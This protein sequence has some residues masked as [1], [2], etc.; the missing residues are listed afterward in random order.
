MEAGP[1]TLSRRALWLIAALA[2][3]YG[4][5]HLSW[6][7][8]TPL[9]QSAVL[10]ERENL[11]LAAQIAHGALPAEPFYRAM[12]YPLLLSGL[13]AAGL[14]PDGLPQAAT[15]LGL[16]L[17]V[18]N[19]VLVARLAQKWFGSA[20][21]G[22]VAGLLHGLNPVLIHYATQILDATFADTFFVLGLLCLPAAPG[23]APARRAALGLSLAWTAAALVRPQFLLLWLALPLV[24]LLAA[25]GLRSWRAQLGPLLLAVTAGAA[26]WLAEGA[27]QWRTG[28][29]FRLLP[30]QG[31]YN[32][33]A[34]NRP[35]ANGRYYTQVLLLETP[36]GATQEN[37]A[38]VE[39]VLLYERATGT[40]GMP[41]IGVFNRYWSD[42]LGRETLAA[43]AAWAGLEL[44][45][46]YYLANH[47]EQYNN[48]TY[49]FHRARSPWLRFNPLGWGFLL[50]G[51][52]LGLIT[53]A[54]TRPGLLRAALVAAGAVAAGVLLS[55]VSARFR[56]PLAVLLCAA[57]GGAVASPRLWWPADP[58]GRAATAL[59]LLALGV[60]TFTSW[61]GAADRSTFVQDH[62]L[63]ASAA[64]HSGDDRITWDEARA[65]LRLRPGYPDALRL[66]LTSYLNLLLEAPQPPAAEAEWRGLARQLHDQATAPV[67][68]PQANV[69]ALAFWRAHDPAGAA[70]WRSRLAAQD[71]PESL[72][73][74]ALAGLAT[75]AELQ[76][77]AALP[78]P[79]TPGSFLLMAKARLA[80]GALAAWAQA[81]GKPDL[82]AALARAA[83]HLFP[84][85][86]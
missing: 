20:R 34:A 19:T 81:H 69:I 72:A 55:F 4:G 18:L 50:L 68:H 38:R 3:L 84:A 70:L 53:L 14:L 36:A 80:P 40:K 2:L 56:L 7:W 52:S 22:L 30:W 29:E 12:G 42:R 51:G 64:E 79:A 59:L 65:A 17:H 27:W 57:A 39:S 62:L 9:G 71:D 28:G 78:W 47:T 23:A 73:A 21:A 54:R 67:T 1:S 24:W 15:A 58:R 86:P 75:P 82:P 45:K 26:L 60:I 49:A 66:A 43:P 63:L 31:P 16:L 46:L 74:L 8:G 10:D 32:L 25:G 83:G 5:A 77:L 35:G 13:S 11:Q 37:P 76:R 44:R 85:A 48:K 33:W 41:P 6:Y 61:F